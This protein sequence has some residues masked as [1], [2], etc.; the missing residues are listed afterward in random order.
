M[1]HS[2]EHFGSGLAG[3][4]A[5]T[6]GT[7]AVAVADS[8]VEFSIAAANDGAAMYKSFDHTKNQMIVVCSRGNSANAAPYPGV[9]IVHGATAPVCDTTTNLAAKWLMRHTFYNPSAARQQRLTYYDTGAVELR[10]SFSTNTWLSA[11]TTVSVPFDTPRDDFR[12]QGIQWDASSARFRMFALHGA[13][14]S[15]ENPDYGPNLIVLTDWVSLSGVQNG[16]S[17]TLWLLLGQPNTSQF[18]AASSAYVEWVSHTWSEA[19][20]DFAVLCNGKSSVG[21]VY[22][23]TAHG[24]Y[25]VRAPLLL[26]QVRNAIAIDKGSAGAWDDTDTQWGSA[27]RAQDGLYVSAY[28][29]DAGTGSTPSPVLEIGIA[30]ATSLDGTWTK[31]ASNPV[32]ARGGAGSAYEYRL[33]SAVLVE[34][35]QE[36]DAARR[37]KMLT[38]CDDAASV[39]RTLVFYAASYTGP[40]TYDGVLL[41]DDA[42]ETNVSRAGHPVYYNGHWLFFYTCTV[43]G[44]QVTRCAFSPQLR[45]GT[46]TRYGVTIAKTSGTFEQTVTSVAAGN[47]VTVPSTTGAVKDMSLV[48]TQTASA[49]TYGKS[50]IRKV[51]SGTV[52]EL[53]HSVPGLAASSVMRSSNFNANSDVQQVYWTGNVF[54]WITTVLGPF[55][56]HGSFDAHHESNGLYVGGASPFDAVTLDWVATPFIPFGQDS[57]NTTVSNENPRVVT[58]PVR[59]ASNKPIHDRQ[60]SVLLR[61]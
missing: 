12:M 34:D 13:A 59:F 35:W 15:A 48:I 24:G 32:I 47:L 29:G 41:A 54:Y 30:T 14:G 50:R 33:L 2:F 25:D 43:A 1:A 51:V 9:A 45:A 61:R 16:A 27:I 36:S 10:W 7:G 58:T 21:G 39:R 19:G 23:I 56:G 18:I 22:N 42:T 40:Y 52:L 11:G 57:A 20:E 28:V 26:P 44:V 8:M 6:A 53:Y 38:S 49:N 4:T 5:I 3:W 60:R 37:Y 46:M 55:S 17:S 31:Y